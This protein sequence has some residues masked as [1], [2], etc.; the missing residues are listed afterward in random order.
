MNNFVERCLFTS[1]LG[2]GWFNGWSGQV[3][4]YRVSG[5]DLTFKANEKVIFLVFGVFPS[6]TLGYTMQKLIAS[7]S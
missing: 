5:R 3:P 4:W 6:S 1:Y 7:E 2:S